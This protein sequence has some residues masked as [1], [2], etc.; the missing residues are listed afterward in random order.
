LIV[1]VLIF[2]W[3]QRI[4]QHNFVGET[5]EVIDIQRQQGI[6]TI[7]EH[8]CNDIGIMHLFA[9]CW[10]TLKQR[11]ELLRYGFCLIRNVKRRRIFRYCKSI[12]EAVIGCINNCGRVA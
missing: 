6:D 10:V 8:S 7:G 12:W 9:A 3:L 5:L 4:E 11:D 2:L 1:C